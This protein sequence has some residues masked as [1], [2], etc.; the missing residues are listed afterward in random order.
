MRVVGGT[1]IVKSQDPVQEMP[2]VGQAG[3]AV[4]VGLVLSNHSHRA[5]MRVNRNR[6][7]IRDGWF[8]TV[9]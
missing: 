2:E 1:G 4:V 7:C 8:R 9:S 6:L 3:G 5:A